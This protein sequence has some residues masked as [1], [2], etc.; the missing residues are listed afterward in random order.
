MSPRTPRDESKLNLYNILIIGNNNEPIFLDDED[1]LYMI[2]QLSEKSSEA[3]CD[4]YAYCIL[5]NKANFLLR[6]RE[7]ELSSIMRRLNMAY[8]VY[9]NRKYGRCGHVF[10][11]RYRSIAIN[12]SEYILPV[13]RSIH[14]MPKLTGLDSEYT[15][16]AFSSYHDYEALANECDTVSICG[17]RVGIN[18]ILAEDGEMKAFDN[19]VCFDDAEFFA[20]RLAEQ[21][22]RMNELSFE[23]LNEKGS[24][25]YRRELVILIRE[26][27]NCS[28]RKISDILGIN[29]GEVYK[30]ITDNKEDEK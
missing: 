8:A 13:I 10:H 30:F 21:Y 25:V 12:G 19:S 9:F 22:M 4:F 11:D 3:C 29:R 26:K 15:K 6:P 24:Y 5:P 1:K 28:I 7:E 18:D 20:R 2:S 14:A 16:Y 23:L 17:C 27:T